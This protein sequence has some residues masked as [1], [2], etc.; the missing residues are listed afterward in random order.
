M[1]P[2]LELKDALHFLRQTTTS[3]TTPKPWVI[4]IL[5]SKARMLVSECKNMNYEQVNMNECFLESFIN[6]NKIFG[7]YYLTHGTKYLMTWKNIFPLFM[8]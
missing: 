7:K 6:V 2:S 3:T 4:V 8:D 1:V 5:D